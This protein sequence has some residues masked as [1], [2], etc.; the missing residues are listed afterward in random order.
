M[1]IFLTNKGFSNARLG[2][3]NTVFLA[4]QQ[5]FDILGSGKFLANDFFGP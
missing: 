4:N 5:K 1:C 2:F 3:T